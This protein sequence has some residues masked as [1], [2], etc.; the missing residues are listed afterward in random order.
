MHIM[1]CRKDVLLPECIPYSM[2][3]WHNFRHLDICGRIDK[4]CSIG[5]YLYGRLLLLAYQYY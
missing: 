4:L 1:P 3:Y 2:P 5:Y